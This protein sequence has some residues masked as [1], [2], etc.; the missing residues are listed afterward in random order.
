[1]LL[2]LVLCLSPTRERKHAFLTLPKL[3][4]QPANRSSALTL[5]TKMPQGVSKAGR[6]CEHGFKRAK[7]RPRHAKCTPQEHKVGTITKRGMA[8]GKPTLHGVP[9]TPG[10]V[11][12]T[13]SP[14][15][16]KVRLLHKWEIEAHQTFTS[17][18]YECQ[19]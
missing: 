7:Q 10:T 1:M 13:A 4:Q 3:L 19:V 8:R 14:S 5:N 12:K 2:I 15:Q 18:F 16:R 9:S 17:C 11:Y 6:E